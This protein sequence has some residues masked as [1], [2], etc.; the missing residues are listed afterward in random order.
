MSVEYDKRAIIEM[1]FIF[2]K[3]GFRLPPKKIYGIKKSLRASLLIKKYEMRS[4]EF[5]GYIVKCMCDYIK[6]KS[7]KNN[8][9][10]LNN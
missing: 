4:D 3:M 10:S 6:N 9:E 7:I 8:I 5:Y 1:L 2:E